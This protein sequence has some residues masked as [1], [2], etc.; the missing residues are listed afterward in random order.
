MTKNANN[1]AFT[2]LWKE[3]KYIYIYIYIYIYSH[4]QTDCFVV[5]QLFRVARHVGC[6]KLGSK[7][8]QRYVRLNIRLL[9]QQAY[10]VGLG[11]YKV[12]CSN[13]SIR[14]FT[15]IPY[16]IPECSIRSKSFALCEWQLKIPSPECSTPM[17][18][19]VCLFLCVY[20]YLWCTFVFFVS[21][22]IYIY[23]YNVY[24]CIY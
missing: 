6:S 21:E 13:S 8:I 14:L 17:E 24:L 20:I 12:L 1:V 18:N 10:H 16:R 4:P 7:P 23:I 3:F 9:S 15:F 11:N 19:I 2:K 5:S 22:Y